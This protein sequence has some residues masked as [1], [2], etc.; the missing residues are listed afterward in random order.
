M[1]FDLPLDRMTATEKIALMERI[2]SDLCRDPESVV[3]PD[4][5]EEV[6]AKR[7]ERV[8]A[9]QAEFIALETAMDQIR[10]AV[11]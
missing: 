10:K 5:H 1:E 3:S 8:L 7:N 4:W 11:E 9:G 6:L 2:W